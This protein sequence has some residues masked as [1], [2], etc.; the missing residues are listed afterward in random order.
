MD[1]ETFSV[2]L[3]KVKRTIT[4]FQNMEPKVLYYP[5]DRAFPLVDTYYKDEFGKLVGIQATI[6][7]IHPKKEITYERF[8]TKIGT[9]PETTPL[10]LY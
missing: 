10:K 5:F 2:K 7:K 1:W 4:T 6:T 3:D 8:Y 9:D